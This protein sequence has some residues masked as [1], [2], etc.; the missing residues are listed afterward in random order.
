[1]PLRW[2][3]ILLILFFLSSCAPKPKPQVTPPPPDTTKVEEERLTPLEEETPREEEEEYPALPEGVHRVLGFRVHVF[4]GT[5]EEAVK[6]KRELERE[7]D[8]K[9]HLES[10][11][12]YYYVEVGDFTR[13]DLA[14]SVM[15]ILLKKGYPE[16]VVIETLVE[17]H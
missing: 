16:A 17:K 14:E 8:L 11:P 12:P 13:R 7:T 2:L 4:T 1:M 9:V 6:V 3:P 5:Y 10:N 15:K